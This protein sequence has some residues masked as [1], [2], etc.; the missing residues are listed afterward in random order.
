SAPARRPAAIS[1]SEG[2]VT[3]TRSRLR[4]DLAALASSPVTTTTT[5]RSFPHSASS[6]APAFVDG[7]A[8][9]APS[10][11]ASVPVA[12]GAEGVVRKAARRS[13]GLTLNETYRGRG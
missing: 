8:N 10:K 4:N 6:A 12:A 1:S 2:V 3:T 7:S 9:E 5:G 11:T 13:L